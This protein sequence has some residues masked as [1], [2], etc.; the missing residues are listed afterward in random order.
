MSIWDLLGESRTPRIYQPGQFI[1]FQGTQPDCF[2]YLQTGA[3]RSFISSPE[4]EERVITV[5]RAGSLMGE[6]SFF[7][8]CPRVTSAT[9][10]E[11]CKVY[12]VNRQ[13]LDAIFSRHPEL[14]LPMLQYLARTVRIL[15]DHVD[16]ASLPAERR[17]VRY[18]LAQH[19]D[20][21]GKILSTHE[22]IGQAVGVSRVTVSRVLSRL[23]HSGA[24]E[25]GYGQIYIKN[26]S[27]LQT[28]DQ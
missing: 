13:Q 18:L 24:L 19:E 25:T 9:A 4:G 16:N 5:H 2:Y 26:R 10:L 11:E 17:I 20:S 22:D 27:L 21:S 1:Y 3:A 6:A 15:S 23:S 28:F 8:Q 7:D 12:S 14:A